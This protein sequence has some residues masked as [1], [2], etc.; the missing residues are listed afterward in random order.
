MLKALASRARQ[1]SVRTFLVRVSDDSLSGAGVARNQQLEAVRTDRFE[2][3]DL[4]VFEAGAGVVLAMFGSHEPDGS[5]RFEGAHPK[6]PTRRFD[7]GEVRIKGV[8]LN[9]PRRESPPL[10]RPP[11]GAHP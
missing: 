5:Y 11:A 10:A 2:S 9:L 7:P 6:C 4:V 1:H 8:V 3:G